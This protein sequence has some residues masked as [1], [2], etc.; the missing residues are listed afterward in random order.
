MQSAKVSRTN[1]RNVLL[2]Y[3]QVHSTYQVLAFFLFYYAQA[4]IALNV[5]RTNRKARTVFQLLS[6]VALVENK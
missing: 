1:R 4:R 3:V 6:A 5:L 2:T